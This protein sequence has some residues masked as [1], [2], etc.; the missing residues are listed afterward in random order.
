MRVHQ[1]RHHRHLS[2]I[3]QRR[4][5]PERKRRAGASDGRNAPAIEGDPA[6]QQRTVGNRKN[7]AGAKNQHEGVDGCGLRD[8]EWGDQLVWPREALPCL[9]RAA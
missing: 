3:H 1:R 6:V 7:P 4:V 2:Q 9:E 8:I 5:V